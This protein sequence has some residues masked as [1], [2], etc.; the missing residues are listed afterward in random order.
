MTKTYWWLS[1][2]D[3]ARPKGEQFLGA[4]IVEGQ[5][6]GDAVRIAWAMD[7]NPGGEVRGMQI[8]DHVT[9]HPSR[10]GVLMDRAEAEALSSP[11][12]AATPREVRS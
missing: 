11:E 9:V 7:C 2:C 4:C 6:M 8:G 10:I 5:S 3:A 12:M 1:F